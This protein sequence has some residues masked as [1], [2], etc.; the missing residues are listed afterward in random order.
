MFR[1][2]HNL[3]PEFIFVAV[4]L[5][6]AVSSVATFRR[7]CSPLGLG[8]TVLC[9][10]LLM[11]GAAIQLE[12]LLRATTTWVN[13]SVAL[14]IMVL[15]PI[16]CRYNRID[17]VEG[18][19]APFSAAWLYI[20]SG[21]VLWVAPRLMFLALAGWGSGFGLG[22]A[23]QRGVVES[24]TMAS[25]ALML[26]TLPEEFAILLLALLLGLGIPHAAVLSLWE[27]APLK[28]RAMRRPPV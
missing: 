11:F 6:G 16:V 20:W 2:P 17:Y 8:L 25:N 21:R 24:A 14:A 26:Q 27:P 22:L 23:T 15:A 4:V 12:I 10:L 18:K 7:V 3:S 1:H 19:P 9:G 5:A 13:L 28:P